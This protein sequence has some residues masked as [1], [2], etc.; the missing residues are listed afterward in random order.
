MSSARRRAVTVSDRLRRA[1]G[2]TVVPRPDPDDLVLREYA[3]A[4]SSLDII[5]GLSFP[6]LQACLYTAMG[7]DDAMRIVTPGLIE[8]PHEQ[9]AMYHR[10]VLQV[11][12]R[13]G[14][15]GEREDE[16]ES[17]RRV[18]LVVALVASKS[19]GVRG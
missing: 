18:A 1:F 19:A 11:L 9:I 12:A 3:W 13:P 4:C 15:D 16:L 14:G 5:R 8:L 17:D 10:R 7:H 6:K 2:P